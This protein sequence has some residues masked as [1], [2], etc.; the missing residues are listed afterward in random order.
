[1]HNPKQDIEECFALIEA[2]AKYDG[3]RKYRMTTT[4]RVLYWTSTVAMYSALI[5]GIYLIIK[6]LF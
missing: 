1:M 6:F 4:D 3:H 2:G 5:G